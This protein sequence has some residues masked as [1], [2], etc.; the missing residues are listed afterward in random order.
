M[1][2]PCQS[3]GGTLSPCPRAPR[4]AAPRSTS[5]IPERAAAEWQLRY[6]LAATLFPLA[7]SE[8]PN[9]PLA[10]LLEASDRGT[11]HPTPPAAHEA[12][13][14]QRRGMPRERK[15]PFSSSSP[16]KSPIWFDFST[17]LRIIPTERIA[18]TLPLCPQRIQ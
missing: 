10:S 1:S 15:P 13:G 8:R 2:P 6:A 5:C 14:L 7:S 16:V 18:G 9:R 3:P 4:H 11:A 12:P 17:V